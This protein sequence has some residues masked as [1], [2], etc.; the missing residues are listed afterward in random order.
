[1]GVWVFTQVKVQTMS[2]RVRDFLRRLAAPV[3]NPIGNVEVDP[4]IDPFH[5]DQRLPPDVVA[6][7]TLPCERCN[8]PP[9]LRYADPADYHCHVCERPGE[10]WDLTVQDRNLGIDLDCYRTPDGNTVC[11]HAMCNLVLLCKAE[12]QKTDNAAVDS[13]S[14]DCLNTELCTDDIRR[15]LDDVLSRDGLVMKVHKSTR[16]KSGYPNDMLVS[17]SIRLKRRRTMTKSARKR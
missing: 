4:V 10:S 1:M 13:V 7:D 6:E 3:V 5:W 15:A 14:R 2:V 16:A 8:V 17:L 9:D 11:L 12:M